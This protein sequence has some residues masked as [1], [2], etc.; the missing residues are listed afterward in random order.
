MNY[1]KIMQ[2]I[3]A[4]HKRQREEITNLEYKDALE[5]I[6]IMII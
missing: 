1:T 4:D 3:E 6:R 5:E 2:E